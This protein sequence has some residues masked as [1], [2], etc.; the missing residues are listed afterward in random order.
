MSLWQELTA[1]T[2]IGADV[3]ALRLLLA[4]VLGFV[5]G[6][7]RELKNRTLGLRSFMLVSIGAALFSLSAQEIVH[8]FEGEMIDPTRVVQGIIGGIGFLGAGAIIQARGNIIGGTTGATTWMVGGI[9]MACGF[10]LYLHAVLATLVAV[11]VL[12]VLGLAQRLLGKDSEDVVPVEPSARG[13][14]TRTDGLG[15]DT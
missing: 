14:R 11:F 13:H 8:L 5:I 9:G 3:V 2:A 6:L 7:D 1:T 15:G 10:G 4:A 12:T